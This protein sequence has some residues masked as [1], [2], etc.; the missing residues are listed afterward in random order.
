[1]TT[2]PLRVRGCTRITRQSITRT[3][4]NT[5]AA[6]AVASSLFFSGPIS[7]SLAATEAGDTLSAS[8]KVLIQGNLA[9]TEASDTLSSSGLIYD[10][11]TG[12]QLWASGNRPA[13]G[14]MATTTR[15]CDGVPGDTTTSETG[16]DSLTFSGA[17]A[18]REVTGTLTA[19][20]DFLYP[21]N[22]TAFRYTVS[23]RSVSWVP[24]I[25]LYPPGD[26]GAVTT[27]NEEAEYSLDG[28]SWTSLS[29]TSL[30]GTATGTAI[31]TGLNVNLRYLR[32]LASAS[33]R[34]IQDN[35]TISGT[36]SVSDIRVSAV[37]LPI[38]GVLDRTEDGD[39]LE[40]TGRLLIQGVLTATED[41]DTL[42]ATATIAENCVCDWSDGG[43]VC[44]VTWAQDSTAEGT[45][46][47][48]TE[49][50]GTWAGE[51]SPDDSWAQ[52]TDTAD[53][54]TRGEKCA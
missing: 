48:D 13:I 2:A 9:A 53:A 33:F 41:G 21:H 44:D 39:T 42:S 49:A 11:F 19:V 37:G 50:A 6:V 23:A 14:S 7:G 45:W 40:A 17:C 5:A 52:E 25:C 27:F 28:T 4:Q 30:G 22:L 12:T 38:L 26:P 20:L 1:M 10:S 34:D 16:S 18:V 35:G 43:G 8:G 24:S 46:T 51:T 31:T 54:W 36:A 47:G 3:V 15:F 32:I 29:F